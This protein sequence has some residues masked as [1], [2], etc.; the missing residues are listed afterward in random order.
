L[1]SEGTPHVRRGPPW[2]S[3]D[4]EIAMYEVVAAR[5]MQWDNLVWQVPVITLTGQAFLFTI[6]LSS[7]NSQLARL[8]ASL[9]AF[10]ASFLARQ[11]MSRHRQA[12]LTDA[13]WLEAYEQTRFGTTFHGELWRN[14][15]DTISGRDVGGIFARVPGYYTWM[16]GLAVF[17][18]AALVA[19]FVAWT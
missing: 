17:A 1:R 14:H 19:F 7:G 18:I 4:G 2:G 15:R 8:L 16:L 6:A 11:L 10:V 5:L 13:H 9:L 12:E 3:I